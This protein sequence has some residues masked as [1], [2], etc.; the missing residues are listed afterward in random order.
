MK[1]S[2]HPSKGPFLHDLAPEQRFIGFY[3]TRRKQLD[4]FRDPS[5]GHYLTL[6]LGDRSGQMLARV[7]ENAED[8][9]PEIVQGEVVKVDGE[10]ET[11]LERNQIRVLRVRPASPGEYDIRDMLPASDKDPDEMLAALLSYIQR[12]ENPHLAAVVD[13]FYGDEG[14]L[15]LY[16]QAPAARRIHHAYLHGL[17]EH[18]LE[19]LALSNTL[20]ELYPQVDTDLLLTGILLHDI[21]KLREFT[22]ELDIDYTGEGRL[23]GH[24]VIA[25]E[26]V[27]GAITG[28]P[29]FPPELALRLRHMLLSHHGRY[30]FGSPRRPMT[31]EAIV[32]H[33]LENLSAQANRFYSI[34][35][36]RPPGEEWSEYDRMLGRQLY[37]G[38]SDLNVEEAS[39][40]D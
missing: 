40:E 16:S 30:E 19:L 11:Y 31:L 10:V 32:L 37:A 7:W 24:I 14:F 27:T 29:D 18:T 39:W 4:P 3:L 36:S 5:R 1:E 33:H 34:L 35:E 23:L 20:L 9:F 21:G 22:W 12:I 15:R 25:D 38:S 8:I 28:M 13:T 2:Y 6:I 26:M 17:L